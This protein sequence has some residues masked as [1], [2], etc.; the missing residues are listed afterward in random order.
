MNEVRTYR[1]IEDI[2]LNEKVY[3]LDNDGD[4]LIFESTQNAMDHLIDINDTDPYHGVPA[5]TEEEFN[6]FGI[7]FEEV[8]VV[9]EHIQMGCC[10]VCYS[11]NTDDEQVEDGDG[12]VIAVEC[13]CN[14]CGEDYSVKP[15]L[16]FAYQ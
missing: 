7:Y 2:C 12:N 8:P 4:V 15:E 16:Y 1:F 9:D 3:L 10:P 5:K 11:R 6:D 14:E 13:V